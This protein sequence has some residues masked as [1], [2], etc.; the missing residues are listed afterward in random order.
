MDTDHPAHETQP[1]ACAGGAFDLASEYT[2][3]VAGA[4]PDLP[5]SVGLE[6]EGL[7]VVRQPCAPRKETT[8]TTK[9]RYV[10]WTMR[11]RMDAIWG[12]IV[13]YPSFVAERLELHGARTRPR[14]EW[15]W[16]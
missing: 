10:R 13:M 4:G 16:W 9:R 11:N 12:T 2:P 15:R 3:H 8:M 5:W 7:G 1:L 6:S 14:P